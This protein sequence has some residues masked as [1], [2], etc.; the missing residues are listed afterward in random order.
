MRARARLF[1]HRFEKEL[2]IHIDALEGG[3]PARR[4]AE[5]ERGQEDHPCPARETS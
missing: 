1:L 2:F 3:N 5:S 4:V